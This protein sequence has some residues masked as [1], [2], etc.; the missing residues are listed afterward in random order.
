MYVYEASESAEFYA[1]PPI[2]CWG[3]LLTNRQTNDSENRISVKGVRGKMCTLERV[4]LFSIIVLSVKPLKYLSWLLISDVCWQRVDGTYERST[5]DSSDG[6]KHR[7][8]QKT[9]ASVRAFALLHCDRVQTHSVFSLTTFF[10]EVTW[11]Y[12]DGAGNTVEN[13]SVFSL[14]WTCCLASARVCGQ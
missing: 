9:S 6:A 12:R 11:Q 10:F 3:I 8:N 13:S 1:C 4:W 2:T 5:S 7:S 14:G